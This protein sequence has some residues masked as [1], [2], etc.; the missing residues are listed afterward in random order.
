MQ[1]LTAAFPFFLQDQYNNLP[2]DVKVT[3]LLTALHTNTF[4]EE[5]RHMAAVILRRLF[6]SEFPDFYNVVSLSIRNELVRTFTMLTLYTSDHVSQQYRQSKENDFFEVMSNIQ[7]RRQCGR[8]RRLLQFQK[9]SSFI[10]KRNK[11]I[12]IAICQIFAILDELIIY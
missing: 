10:P 12:R 1:N 3:Q 5:A 6:A 4:K 9:K 8:L 11:K 7:H 2:V